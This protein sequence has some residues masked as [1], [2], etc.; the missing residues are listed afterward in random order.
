[1]REILP[2]A[3]LGGVL[4]LDV[5][6]FPQMMVSRPLVAATLA[7][8][9][10]GDPAMGIFVGVTL[11]LI[12]LATLPFGASR[13]PEWGS[14]AVVGGA[15]AGALHTERAGALSIG[16]LAALATAWVGGWTLVKLRQW[17]AWLARRR[18]PALDAGS[19]GAVMSLQLAGLTADAVRAAALTTVAFVLLFPVGEA[20]LGVW[21]LSEP[22]SRGF[23]VSVA[24][25]VAGAAA[26]TIFHSARGA[27]WYFAGGLLVGLFI[28]LVR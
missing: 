21:S 28:L 18:R 16:V 14:A 27:R 12:A 4:G 7:G 23:V 13:Y 1:M 20:T 8:A 17:V 11:E 5:V 9:F 3:L 19:R 22:L 10:V 6:C 2:L 26:W 24:A 15:I 25:A